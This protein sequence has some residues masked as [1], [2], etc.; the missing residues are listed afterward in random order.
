M[1]NT[2]FFILF[3][4]CIHLS[5]QDINPD[6]FNQ[7]FYPNGQVSSEGYMKNGK[8][9]GFWKSYYVTG[10]K[11]SEG[12]WRNNLLDSIW[13]F[14]NQV[15][16]TIEK[17]NYNLGKKNGY[18]YTYKYD[19]KTDASDPGYIASRELYVNDKR[20]GESY[21]YYENG[22]VKTTINYIDG[23]KQGLGIEYSREG[24]ILTLLE[25]RNDYLIN[26]EPVNRM[27]AGGLKQGVW[28][29]FYDNGQLK[30]ERVYLDDQLNGYYREYDEKGNLRFSLRYENGNVI[31][32]SSE[33]LN[34]VEVRNIYDENGRLVSGGPYRENI[35]IGIHRSYDASGNVTGSTIYD[36]QGNVISEGIV[37]EQGVRQGKWINYFLSG[38]VQSEGSYIENE[39][40]GAWNF[41]RKNGKLEQQGSY[42]N[43]R[44]HGFWKWYYPD[45]TLL[46]E[47]EYFSGKEEGLSVE[48]SQNGEV[49][50]EGNYINGEKEGEWFY[51][52]GDQVEK[53]KY[54]TGLRDGIWE[55]YYPDGSVK[56]SG[57]YVQGLPDGRHKYYYENGRLKEEQFYD[58]G[59]RQKTWKKYD[60]E[61]YVILTINYK[62]DVEKRI[63]GV[64]VDLEQDVK[65]IR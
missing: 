20:N 6:G 10:I 18:Y 27:D 26:R 63:N 64:K 43:D 8:P 2:C 9:D 58:M 16:D 41:Y 38:E 24:E 4:L 7:F 25:Y 14:Y 5:A 33:E 44:I 47:E 35:P 50:A 46:R 40:S 15:G 49:I 1:K 37:T 45:G 3:G 31:N 12:K 11:K 22:Q 34:E 52:V 55:Y 13:V 48:Y 57:Y 23:M 62:D 59:L 61:G 28:K 60:E 51:K 21:Y 17:I 29:E 56:Y 42:R 39:R 53:G 65:R 32:E 54:I 36:N 19:N 30:T